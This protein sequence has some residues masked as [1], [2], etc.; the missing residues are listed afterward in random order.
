MASSITDTTATLTIGNYTG[1]WYYKYTSPTG[2]VCST[3]ALTGTTASLSDLTAETSYT[4]SAY[5]DSGCSTLLATAAAF[6]TL[7]TP[8]VTV[9]VAT[10]NVGIS[11]TATYT[12]VLDARPTAAV[13][14]TPSSNAEAK[15]TVSG[16]LTFAADSWD[17]AQT[18]MV[19]GVAAGSATVSHGVVSTDSDYSGITV[20][21]VSVTVPSRTLV[22][23]S[24]TDTTATLTIGNYTGD[25]YYKYTSP[26]GGVCSTTA[27]TGTTASLSDLTA[28]T[29]YTFSAY[30]DSGCSTLL[31]TAAAFTTL[32]TPGVTVSVATLNVGISSTA[33]YTVVLD[34]R[35]TAAVTVTPS[36]NAE[37]K[38]TVSGALTFATDSWDTAQ[39]VM[40]TGVAA[41]SATVSHGVVSTD[42]DYS[43]ITV[44]GV[45][46]TVPSRTLVASSITDTTATL[47]IGNYTGD[48]YYKYTSPTGGVCSTTALTGTTASLSDLTAETSYTFSAYSDSGCSTLLATA[49]AFTTLSTPGVT[50]SVATLNVGISSTATYT[51]VLDARPTAAVTVTPSSN[52]EAKA[53]VS[54]ALTFA[55]DSWDTAQTVMVTGVAAGSATVSHGVVS[56]DSDYSGITVSGVS[57]TVEGGAGKPPMVEPEVSGAWLSETAIQAISH[58]EEALINRFDAAETAGL[59][60]S[61]AGGT[62]KSGEVPEKRLCLTEEEKEACEAENAE[63]KAR[64]EALVD[65]LPVSTRDGL[66]RPAATD[67]QLSAQDFI[68]GTQFTIGANSDDGRIGTVW[69]RGA[70]SSFSRG[71][72]FSIDGDAWSITVGG[73]YIRGRWRTGLALSR[74]TTKG[75]YDSKT[76]KGRIRTTLTGLYP[77]FSY[78]SSDD[79]SIWG[80]V[81]FGTGKFEVNP[82]SVP[83][84]STD[85]R[86]KQVALGIKYTILSRSTGSGFTLDMKGSGRWL[87]TQ[88]KAA[89]L[90]AATDVTST[91]LRLGLEASWKSLA[92]TGSILTPRAGLSLRY[93][94]GDSGTGWGLEGELGLDWSSADGRWNLGLTSRHLVK[95]EEDD[96]RQW[97]LSA[98]LSYDVNPD[99]QYGWTAKLSPKLQGSSTRQVAPTTGSV[100]DFAERSERKQGIEGEIAYGFP[101]LGGLGDGALTALGAIDEDSRQIGLGY[102]LTVKR[103][104]GR[105]MDFK[106][107]GKAD[108]S[109]GRL[110]ASGV[111]FKWSILW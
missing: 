89:G 9:S 81:G 52:A 38:A 72:D 12:V 104:D 24:I 71:G 29:S 105:E 76:G 82:E 93:D 86:S 1:D 48:W 7:S 88:S 60:A 51:V 94:D 110:R 91:R 108:N 58:V 31:A 10:L 20:S 45:S 68:S 59:R 35:P 69:M 97:T 34:A 106:V 33:T 61:L 100:A 5:S 26:T 43:G 17:T 102:S 18:V 87:N 84:V 47:T 19:T 53:T 11:S 79:L 27:L 4:F 63:A 90:L 41:G 8:G 92:D 77:Y 65:S 54:G 14:V 85:I 50:V 98:L 32:S 80:L 22:A 62:L 83:P 75:S 73:D 74:T 55:A 64:H 37:A 21:G 23:S 78:K 101:Q 66:V 111:E 16:A 28:E 107:I 15:A 57:V 25:W 95:H 3:T 36:S 2:G 44:S 70:V 46:V 6:T 56:T 103:P 49:A 30:S 39:T 13:T 96:Y 99:S 109:S 67:D 42:S 40:V